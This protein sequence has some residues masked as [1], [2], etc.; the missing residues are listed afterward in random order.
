MDFGEHAVGGQAVVGEHHVLAQPLVEHHAAIGGGVIVRQRA[1]GAGARMVLGESRHPRHVEHARLGGAQR[2]RVDVGG[3]DQGAVQQ[4][5]FL[6]QDGQRIH[7]FPRAAPGHPD[8]ERRVGAQQRH[9]LLAQRLEVAGVA[10]HVAHLHGEVFEQRRE[11]GGLVQHA[12]LQLRQRLAVKLH[13]RRRQ[14]PLERRLRVAPEVIV[15]AVVDGVDQQ[16]L[17]DVCGA[18]LAVRHGGAY[19]GIHTRT[20]DS[21]FSTSSGLAM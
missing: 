8:L 13:Q 11:H 7:L 21:S 9:H 5:F 6:Q 17:L 1:T 15:V 10:E 18:G 4:A 3:V 19:L 20:R 16:A 2:V 14:P 12:V